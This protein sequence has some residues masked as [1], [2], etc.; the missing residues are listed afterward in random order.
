MG[1]ELICVYVDNLLITGNNIKN[2]K[3]FKQ[4]IM[5]ELEMSD[6]GNISYFLGM[7]FLKTKKRHDFASEEIY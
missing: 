4:L 2:L 7:E 1:D 6:L 3:K 5:K